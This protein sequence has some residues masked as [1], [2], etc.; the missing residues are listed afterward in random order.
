MCVVDGS[1][2]GSPCEACG[3]SVAC[4]VDSCGAATIDAADQATEEAAV[5]REEEG[6]TWKRTRV[7]TGEMGWNVASDGAAWGWQLGVC[8]W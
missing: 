2:D 5:E 1:V 7:G 8:S 6:Q 3:G 4:G